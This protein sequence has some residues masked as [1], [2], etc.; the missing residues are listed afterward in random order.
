MNQDIKADEDFFGAAPTAQEQLRRWDEGRFI[1]TIS[2]G[3]LGPGYE[4]AIQVLAIEIVRDQLGKPLPTNKENT[5]ANREWGY[6]TVERI[7]VKQADGHYSC[8]GFSGGQVGAA[9]FLAYQWLSIGPK[10]LH[11]DPRYDDRHILAS[12]FWPHVG[13]RA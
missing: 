12:N 1:W 9:R 10:A 11:D 3:G 7:D 2:M 13:Q 8:G 4:Q 6:A 5:E